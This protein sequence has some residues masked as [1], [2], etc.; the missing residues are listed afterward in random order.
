M[1]DN[2]KICLI[3]KDKQYDITNILEKVQWGGDYKS[4][5]RK[6]DFSILTRVTDISISVG[7]FILFY[8][9]NE[10]VF[11]GIVWETSIG[12]GGDS[13]SVLAY[14]NGIYLL[15]NNLAYNF[16]DTK[17]ESIASKVCADLGITVGNIISTGVNITKLFL[18]VSAYEII[19]TAYTEASKKTGKK[20]M[21]YIKDDKLHK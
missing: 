15:K 20:Y 19:M 14:D 1:T 21:C 2:I 8:V 18:G 10:K 4:V 11:K 6:L 9:N 12:S 3:K 13:M 16:K 7:D 17:A 5:A